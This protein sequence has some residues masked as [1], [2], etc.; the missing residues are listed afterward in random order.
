MQEKTK[1]AYLPMAVDMI[2]PGHLNIIK[3]AEKLGATVMVGCYSDEAIASYKRLP[4]MN[5]QQRK[6]VVENI[7]GVDIVVVQNSRD[8]EENIRKYKP[9]YVVHGTDWRDGALAKAREKTITILS[10]WGGELVEPEYTEGISSTVAHEQINEIGTTPATRQVR[11][12]K[13]IAVKNNLRAMEVHN[14]LSAFIVE[15]AVVKNVGEPTEEF[16]ALWFDSFTSAFVRGKSDIEIVDF[17]SKCNVINDIFDVSLKPMIFDGGTGGTRDQLTYMIKTLERMGVSAIVIE[18]RSSDSNLSGAEEFCETIKM[19][20]RS[21]VER[22]FMVIPKVK[23]DS[24]IND[25]V[26]I[27]IQKYIKSGA[28]SIMICGNDY[29][30][31]ATFCNRIRCLENTVP[32]M[33][34]VNAENKL[35]ENDFNKMGV[36][37]ILYS[38]NL[39]KSIIPV[40]EQTT[41][42]ILENKGIKL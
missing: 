39:L 14:G 24:N 15:K 28:D 23:I 32:I 6:E 20:K 3:E 22:H 7:K 29:K 30:Q 41:Q 26:I 17:T 27:N 16:D 38:N 8:L 33:V 34:L 21:Q 40:M 1:L 5:F 37:L 12:R 31:I 2:H 36:N 35:L 4:F 13:L 42:F 9:D 18:D 19:A 25:E 10:E 11:L